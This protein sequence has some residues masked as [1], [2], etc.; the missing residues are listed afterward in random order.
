MK[1]E[2]SESFYILVYLLELIIKIWQF[3]NFIFEIEQS[4]VIF[5]HDKTFVEVKTIFFRSNFGKISPKKG[6]CP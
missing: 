2:K 6:H 5:F 4:W 1:V 3:G